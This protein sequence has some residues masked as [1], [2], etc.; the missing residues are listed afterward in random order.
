MNSIVLQIDLV[1]NFLSAFRMNMY[2]KELAVY[3]LNALKAVMLSNWDTENIKAVA[4]FLVSTI[5]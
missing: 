1:K 5:S 4:A 3:V 2:A